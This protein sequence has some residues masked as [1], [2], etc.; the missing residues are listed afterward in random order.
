LWVYGIPS[1]GGA[2]EL[3]VYGIPSVGGATELWLYGIQSIGGATELWLYVI[4][5]A[6][7]ATECGYMTFRLQVALLNAPCFVQRYF[8]L[9][10]S[11][12]LRPFY[13]IWMHLASAHLNF[14]F[15]FLIFGLTPYA[16]CAPLP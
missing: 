8:F 3:W 13:A 7:G 2:T 14:V 6:G 11:L 5:F 16:V 9:H 4:P 1:V 10:P 12:V 15:F